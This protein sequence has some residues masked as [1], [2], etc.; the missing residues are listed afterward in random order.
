MHCCCIISCK[1]AQSDIVGQNNH[2]SFGSSSLTRLNIY[3]N[4][5]LLMSGKCNVNY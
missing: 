3:D 5:I 2:K 1:K 4:H